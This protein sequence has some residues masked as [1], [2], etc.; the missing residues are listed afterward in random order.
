MGDLAGR[1]LHLMLS[2]GDH[3]VLGPGESQPPS[4]P[5]PAGLRWSAGPLSEFSS[6]PEVPAVDLGRSEKAQ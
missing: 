6:W 1:T 3:K 2:L 4:D 5:G